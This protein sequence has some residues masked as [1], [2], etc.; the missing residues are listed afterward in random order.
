V[1]LLRT[2]IGLPFRWAER[3]VAQAHS[4]AACYPILSDFTYDRDQEVAA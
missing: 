3:R 1:S 4:R 2:I